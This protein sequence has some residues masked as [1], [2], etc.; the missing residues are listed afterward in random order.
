MKKLLFIVIIAFM[1][2]SCSTPLSKESYLKKFDV[3]ISDV[4]RNYKN[5]NEK[6]W[7]KKA[8]MYENFSGKWYDKFEDDF[9]LKE[10]IAIKANQVKWYYYCNLGV[11]TSTVKQLLESLDMKEIK[12]QM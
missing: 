10:H 11:T 1:A 7:K 6:D 12:K 3:F 9:T 8:E 4:S 2:T 5:Y